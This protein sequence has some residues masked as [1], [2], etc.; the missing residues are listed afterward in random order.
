MNSISCRRVNLGGW[1]VLEPVSHQGF[2]LVPW[3]H[4]LFFLFLPS[5]CQ[6]ILIDW[7]R[8][9]LILCSSPA[10]YQQYYNSSKPVDEWTLS[11]AM[12]ADTANGG[13]GQM[14]QHYKT[15]IVGHIF[16]H[17]L[18]CWRLHVMFTDRARFCRDCWCWSKLCSHSARMVGYWN[19]GWRTLL[20]ESILDVS[21]IIVTKKNNA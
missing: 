19:A 13:L 8:K 4:P 10:L 15:F 7:A 14:E 18:S 20:A 1:L 3:T 2:Q 16:L 12:A 6:F 5:L 9:T 17:L 21:Y 11:Q